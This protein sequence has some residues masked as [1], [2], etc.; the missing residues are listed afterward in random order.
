MIDV[1]R[2]G[3]D[4]KDGGGERVEEGRLVAGDEMK[5]EGMMD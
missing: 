3:V 5:R 1:E 2:T 4:E